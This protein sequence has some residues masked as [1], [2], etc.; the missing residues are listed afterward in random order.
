MPSAFAVLL[1]TT[2]MNLV[3]RS[4]GSSLG[5]APLENL[6]DENGGATKAVGKDQPVSNQ[7]AA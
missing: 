3:A 7:S 4:T 5:F 1:L 2:V 6:V